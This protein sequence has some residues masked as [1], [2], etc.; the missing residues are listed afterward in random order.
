MMAKPMKTRELHYTMIQFLI[1]SHI[2]FPG[3]FGKSFTVTAIRHGHTGHN[4]PLSARKKGR[5]TRKD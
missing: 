4:K 3:S 2:S 1:M 5:K